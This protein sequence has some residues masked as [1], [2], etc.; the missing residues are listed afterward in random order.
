MAY[1]SLGHQV[2]GSL[3]PN[4]ALSLL[5]THW[6]SLSSSN[7]LSLFSHLGLC[8]GLGTPRSFLCLVFLSFSHQ[9]RYHLFSEFSLTTKSKLALL[10]HPYSIVSFHH[11]SILLPNLFSCALSVSHPLGHCKYCQNIEI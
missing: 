7:T 8:T 4:S 6:P 5:Q 2:S 3:M 11:H 9:F 1:H 10:H